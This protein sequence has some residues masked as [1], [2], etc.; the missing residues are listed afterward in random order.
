MSN[1]FYLQENFRERFYQLPKVFFTNETYKKLSND[2]KIAYAILR[3]RLE[4]S[5]KNNWIDSDNAIYFIY[6]NENLEHILNVSKPKVIKIK[7]ELEKVDLL[8]QKRLG[9][10]KPNM[11]YLMKPNVTDSD[12]YLMQNADISEKTPFEDSNDKE[13]KNFNFQKLKKFTS[14][15]EEN[16]LQEVNKINSNDTDISDTNFND[17]NLNETTTTKTLKG[18]SSRKNNLTKLLKEELA[19]SPTKAFVE[20]IDGLSNNMSNELL[21]YAIKYASENGNNPKQY[22]TK[23]LNVWS[24]NNI[25]TIEEAKNFKVRSKKH[26]VQNLEKTPRW[27]T[28]PE[29]FKLSDENTDELEAEALAFIEYLN[30]KNRL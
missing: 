15:S 14:R 22:L 24:E 13:V 5:I 10:N 3:D 11:L 25:T 8:E 9:L 12:I 28:H 19:T 27:I 20:K 18:G 23:V 2:A 4:L 16:L 17:T 1:K 30:N 29:E 21:E 7:K 26:S 6:T